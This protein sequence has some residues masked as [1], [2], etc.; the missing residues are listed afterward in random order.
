MCSDIK[1]SSPFELLPSLCDHCY[2]SVCLFVCLCVCRF[3]CL[4]IS[5]CLSL[6]VRAEKGQATGNI[7]RRIKIRK[8]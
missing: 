1:V 2:C 6:S 4:I 3:V 7:S 8:T 5:V